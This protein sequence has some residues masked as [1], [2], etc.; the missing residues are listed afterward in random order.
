[1]TACKYVITFNGSLSGLEKC[2]EP[3]EDVFFYRPKI[4]FSKNANMILSS[5]SQVKQKIK[6][7][8]V[9][10]LKIIMPSFDSVQAPGLDLLHP[11]V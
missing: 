5:N 3:P 4:E 1:M 2:P 10:I 9:D 11:V 8:V 7:W 6:K